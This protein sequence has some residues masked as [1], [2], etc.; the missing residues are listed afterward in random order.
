MRNQ[1]FICSNNRYRVGEGVVGGGG[2]CRAYSEAYSLVKQL[3][4]AQLQ[5]GLFLKNYYEIS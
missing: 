4:C 3:F 5:A 2:A 1:F